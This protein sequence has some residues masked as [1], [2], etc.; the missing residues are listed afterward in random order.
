MVEPFRLFLL[1][2]PTRYTS[3]RSDHEKTPFPRNLLFWGDNFLNSEKVEQHNEE[4][5]RFM[6][7]ALPRGE[8]FR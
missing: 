6:A 5:D 3:C 4:A 8:R 7:D 2:N 1:P